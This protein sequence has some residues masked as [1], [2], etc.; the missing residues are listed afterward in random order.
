MLAPMPQARRRYFGSVRKLPS[1]RYQA[2]YHHLGAAHSALGTFASKADAFAWLSTVETDIHRGRWVD[3]G[4]GKVTFGEYADTWLGQRYDLRPRTV[5][6][7]RSILGRHL[8]PGFD[9]VP[10]A[11]ITTVVVRS[12][13]ARVAKERPLVAAKSYRL[14]RT[15]LNT[16][17]ADGLIVANPCTIKG[18]GAERTAERRIPTVETVYAIADE[19]GD[20]YR[21]LVLT[22]ALAGLRLG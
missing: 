7:Y 5:E 17:A 10:L 8:R 19:A 12:W 9:Q 18:A 14:L 22:A 13:H 16:A 15:I 1:G 21:A 2:S 6:L 11:Q 3:P 4:A 20:R